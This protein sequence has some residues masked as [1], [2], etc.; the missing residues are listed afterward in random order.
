MMAI[1]VLLHIAVVLAIDNFD[2]QLSKIASF[3]FRD[4][5]NKQGCLM[6]TIN[7]KCSTQGASS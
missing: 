5:T 4:T 2:L 3:I 7:I 1:L 6:N